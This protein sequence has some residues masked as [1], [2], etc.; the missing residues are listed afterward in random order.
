MRQSTP[1][2]LALLALQLGLGLV[3]FGAVVHHV[4][5]LD[6]KPLAA[7]G[8]PILLIYFGFASLQYTRARSVAKGIAQKRSLHAAERAVQGTVW[9]LL[10]LMVGTG[11]YVLLTH[12]GL[13]FGLWL[14][15][16]LVPY[17]LMQV[18]LSS[19]VR[20]LWTIAPDFL[21]PVGPAELARRVQQ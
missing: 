12:F 14:L 7:F 9:H 20:G 13:G 3:F 10:G 21:R 1:R 6:F 18:G 8:L 5:A 11:L 4:A 17:A 16:F 19:F 15:L 2:R